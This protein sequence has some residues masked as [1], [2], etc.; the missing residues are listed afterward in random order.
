MAGLACCEQ[1]SFTLADYMDSLRDKHYRDIL[2]PVFYGFLI[3]RAEG[4]MALGKAAPG[5]LL[6]DFAQNV[7]HA[8]RATMSSAFP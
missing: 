4:E 1:S 5:A 6:G 7:P 3:A 8:R 2:A